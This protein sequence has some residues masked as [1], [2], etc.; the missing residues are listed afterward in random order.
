[1]INSASFFAASFIEK[2]IDSKY[3]SQFQFSRRRDVVL[4]DH[5]LVQLMV[6]KHI[7]C[8]KV[9]LFHLLLYH[10]IE[11]KQHK[12]QTYEPVSCQLEPSSSP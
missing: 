1:M 9:S 2:M 5:V 4:V 3:R 10:V 8:N 11:T 7:P 6:G 12:A